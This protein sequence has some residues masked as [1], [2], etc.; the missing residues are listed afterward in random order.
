MSNHDSAPSLELRV[1]EGAQRGARAPLNAGVSCVLATVADNDGAGADIVL[2]EEQGAPARVRIT[3]QADVPQAQL[4]VLHG[5][6]QLGGAVLATGTQSAWPMYAPLQIGRAIVAFGL[7]RLETWPAASD[8]GHAADA[9]PTPAQPPEPSAPLSRRAEVWLA[10][11]GVI[12]LLICGGAFWTAHLA[13]APRVEDT[14]PPSLSEALKASEFSALETA[15][16]KDGQSEIRGRLRTAQQRA[17]LDAW[18]AERQHTPAVDVQ[19]DESLVRD[20]TETFRINGVSVQ[21]QVAGTGVVT[22]EAAERDAD[23]LARAEEVVR[24]DVRGLTKL[25]VANVIE[26]LPKPMPRVADDPGKRIASLVPGEPA[27]IVTADGSRY[28]VGAVLPTGHRI[29]QIAAQSVTLEFDGQ[30]S[31]LNF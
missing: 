9:E 10:T 5:E 13:A 28:F 6:V 18:L 29:T 31:T 14:A 30:R 20:V 24:R 26:P 11:T 15:V 7:A 4:E 17:R 12:V 21:A 27:Y 2:R 22:V 3:K 19:V 16:R 8:E 25:T 23:R 1:L